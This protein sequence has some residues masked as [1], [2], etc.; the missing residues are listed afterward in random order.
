MYCGKKIFFYFLSSFCEY[1][2]MEIGFYGLDL[3]V[4]IFD[5]VVNF[6]IYLLYKI[7]RTD[8]ELCGYLMSFV[9][10]SFCLIVQFFDFFFFDADDK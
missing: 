4:K 7:K 3:N 1:F 8:F 10:Y 2:S 5:I 6:I 9:F